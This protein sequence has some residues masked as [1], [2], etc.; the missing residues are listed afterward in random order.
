[1]STQY[2]K[3]EIALESGAPRLISARGV[4]AQP[5]PEIMA[6]SPSPTKDHGPLRFALR[7]SLLLFFGYLKAPVLRRLNN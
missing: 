1:M 4:T 7:F 3:R 6:S 5:S 2:C